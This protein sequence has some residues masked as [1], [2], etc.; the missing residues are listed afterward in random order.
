MDNTSSVSESSTEA[1]AGTSRIKTLVFYFIFFCSGASALIF[2]TLWFR[3]AGLTFGNSVWAGSMVLASFMAGLAL[4]NLFAGRFGHKSKQPIRAYGKLEFLIG[5]FGLGLVLLF[6]QFN[7]RFAPLFEPYLEQPLILNP[8]RLGLGFM[9]MLPA[10]MAMG[11]TLPFMVRGLSAKNSRFGVRLGKLYALNTLGAMAG[12]LVCEMVLIEQLG[13]QGTGFAA[14]ALN[15]F[16]GMTAILVGKIDPAALPAIKTGKSTRLNGQQFRILCA[17]FLAGGIL[18]ALEVVWFRY[19][20]LLNFGTSQVFAVMLAV[21]LSGISIGGMLASLWLRKRDARQSLSSIAVTSGLLTLLCYAVPTILIV[22]QNL[23]FQTD[24]TGL[25]TLG[26]SLIVMFPVSMLSGALFTM[27]GAALHADGASETKTTGYLTLFNT[28]GAMCGA[29][30]GGFCLI[31]MLGIERSILWLSFGYVLVSALCWIRWSEMKRS[32][33]WTVTTLTVLLIGVSLGYPRGVTN[34]AMFF[35]VAGVQKDRNKRIVALREGL[36]ETVMYSQSEWMGH[37]LYH[38]LIT[39]SHSMSGTSP[40]AWQYMKMYV[41]LPVAIHPASRKSL[42]ISYGCGVTGKALT[43]TK[44]F[45]QIDI[46]DISRDILDLNRVV[47]PKAEECPL[48]DPRVRVFIEDGRFFLQTTKERYDLITSEPPPP[49]GA[50]VVNLYTQE[51][52]QLIHDRLASGGMTSYWL[53]HHSLNQ[54]DSRTIVRAF[55]EVFKDSSLWL[56]SGDNW[57]LLGIRDGHKTVTEERFRKQW[58]DPDVAPIL[59]ACGFEFPEQMG[60][61]FICD[62]ELMMELTKDTL[63]LADNFPYR[64]KPSTSTRTAESRYAELMDLKSSRQRFQTCD[65]IARTFPKSMMEPSLPYFDQRNYIH[66]IWASHRVRFNPIRVGSIR[67]LHM[68]QANTKLRMPVLWSL[69]TGYR[70]QIVVDKIVAEGR[71]NVWVVEKLGHRGLADRDF[72]AAESKYAK[73]I[74][75]MKKDTLEFQQNVL[76]RT[77]VLCMLGKKIEAQSCVDEHLAKLQNEDMAEDWSYLKET[78]DL[79][80]PNNEIAKR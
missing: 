26:H 80:E 35:K 59:A 50:N 55:C 60:S 9:L 75:R 71:A 67:G 53:P 5:A 27:M 4:G 20:L 18:L 48:N 31:P 64:M 66:D 54:E 2:E 7:A 45:T 30:L 46:V 78:F 34:N 10:T 63:P 33:R 69:N 74:K 15:V 32:S 73:C 51:Y 70:D 65:H 16:V 12:T 17:T 76:R 44:E 47:F 52:F 40:A 13:I 56:G 43:D 72:A 49:K 41:Y 25:S 19:L 23:K 61:Y 3:Q 11:A 62:R 6:P 68:L 77:Y 38:Q 24:N 58:Q 39:N 36:T 1:A 79:A 22:T 14:A 42:L 8:L 37:P 28:T 21:V 29:L 57:M